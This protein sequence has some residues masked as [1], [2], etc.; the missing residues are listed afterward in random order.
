MSR[1]RL[2]EI[3][4]LV[5]LV[6]MSA[7]AQ[8]TTNP[9]FDEDLSGWLVGL[10]PYHLWSAVDSGDSSDSGSLLAF[11]DT[12]GGAIVR[13]KQCVTVS[14]G[15]TLHF[16]VEAF[17]LESGNPADITIDLTPFSDASCDTSSGLNRV[18][19]TPAQGQWT[20]IIHGPHVVDEGVQSIEVSLGLSETWNSTVPVSAHFDNATFFLFAD[21]FE[22]GT[23]TSWSR[24]VPFCGT[25]D[26]GLRVEL[27]WSTTGDPDPGD[28]VGTDLDLHLL[29]PDG[30]GGWLGAYDC[31]QAN[32]SPDWGTA[33]TPNDPILLRED[34]DGVGPEIVQITTPQ[35]AAYDIG[36]LY[37]DHLG[38]GASEA[39]VK[40]FFDGSLIYQPA[41][42]ALDDGE[43]WHVASVEWSG[44]AVTVVD[45]VTDGV[46]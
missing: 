12:A 11:K 36:V 25:P 45:T 39:T 31:Y 43:F 33:G 41:G 26:V 28:S 6:A 1:Y 29:H 19:V 32:S 20:R 42:K 15:T 2:T 9:T 34:G 5:V 13:A 4:A 23:C 8:E 16:T 17:V 21:G 27:T 46:P 10:E 22:T 40:V 44:G 24:S 18:V 30:S 7:G 38:F 35:S 37:V 14:P 3:V